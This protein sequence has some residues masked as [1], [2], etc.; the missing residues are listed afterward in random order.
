MVTHAAA[1]DIGLALEPPSSINNDIL[2]SNK[3]FTYLLA[4][5]AVV[6]TRT[7]GQAAL[8]AELGPAAEGCDVG[9][10]ASFAGAVERLIASPQRL[11]EAR[12]AAWDLGTCRFNWDLEK[13]RF[14]E[15]VRT[16]AAQRTH[17]V[18]GR[19]AA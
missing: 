1:C 15:V 7:R 11:L 9:D 3:I 18:S 4:G 14:L 12:R 5:T 13:L 10:A 16:I 8:L 17:V 6:A 19:P 2:L